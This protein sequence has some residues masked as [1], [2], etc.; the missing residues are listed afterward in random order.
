ML[1]FSLIEDL[2]RTGLA[3]IDDRQQ[4]KVPIG[5]QTRPDATH[6]RVSMRGAY[7]SGCG[8]TGGKLAA[9]VSR[10]AHASH[11]LPVRR[12]RQLLGDDAGQA[13]YLESVLGLLDRKG[14]PQPMRIGLRVYL[15]AA[16]GGTTVVRDW[17]MMILLAGYSAGA[18]DTTPPARRE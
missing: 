17:R 16:R 2:L 4:T 13:R 8:V 3:D 7:A 6:G 10:A 18:P 5:D 9:W 12:L 14:R 1:P 15:A 11:L